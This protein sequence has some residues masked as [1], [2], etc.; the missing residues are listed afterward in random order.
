MPEDEDD[1]QIN[2]VPDEIRDERLKSFAG[3]KEFA[4]P[5]D[6][7]KPAAPY[8]SPPYLQASYPYVNPST[9][10]PIK[11]ESVDWGDSNS[12]FTSASV[13]SNSQFTTTGDF[14]KKQKEDLQDAMASPFIDMD[15]VM[16]DMMNSMKQ[17]QEDINKTK[18]ELSQMARSMKPPPPPP[19]PKFPPTS[20]IRESDVGPYCP[21]CGSSLKRKWML[22]K[23]EKCIQPE[24]ENY[25]GRGDQQGS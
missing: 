2:R 19:P 11:I 5:E 4:E 15:K 9:G 10:S 12:S 21:K 20:M 18:V 17:T 23:S 13:W 3:N 8:P 1:I 24:C 25:Y 16:G 22:F 14:T 6:K 7:E